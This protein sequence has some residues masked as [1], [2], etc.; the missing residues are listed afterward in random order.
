MTEPDEDFAHGDHLAPEE[1]DIEAPADD[2]VEQAT[3]ARPADQEPE[4]H[5][6]FEVNDWDALEQAR[7]VDLDDDYR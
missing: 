6:G 5:R 2:A 7:V 3:L 4:V 1:R